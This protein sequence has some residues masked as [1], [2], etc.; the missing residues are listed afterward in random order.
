MTPA[1]PGRPVAIGC[2]RAARDLRL[3]KRPLCYIGHERLA[4]SGTSREAAAM[5]ASTLRMFRGIPAAAFGLAVILPA[6]AWA[7]GG[8]SGTGGLHGGF[9]FVPAGRTAV[10]PGQHFRAPD[11]GRGHLFGPGRAFRFDPAPAPLRFR[12][13]SGLHEPRGSPFRSTGI[14]PLLGQPVSPFSGASIPPPLTGTG[15][16]AAEVWRWDGRVWQL[17]PVGRP[18]GAWWRSADGIWHAEAAGGGR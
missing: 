14:P 10:M 7:R 15:S 13:G 16:G 6:A 1:A 17:D 9:A 12:P 5:R 2:D 8:Q 11:A 18:G 4:R 3:S